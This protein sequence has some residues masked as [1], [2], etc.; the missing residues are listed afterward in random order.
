MMRWG[1]LLA[2]VWLSGVGGAVSPDPKDLAITPADLARARG[3]V[4]RLGSDDFQEREAAQAELALMGRLARPVL[5][6]ASTA[7]SNPEVRSR[8][9]RLLPRAEAQ[10]LKARIDTFRADESSRYEHDL[11]AWKQFRGVVGTDQ[12][13]RELYV[14]MLQ[15]PLDL[16]LLVAIDTSESEAGKAIADR[17]LSMYYKL[18]PGSFGRASPGVPLPAAEPPTAADV[19]VLMFA[20]ILV[21]SRAIPRAPFPF[22]PQITT[23]AFV[24]Q[25]A[26]HNALNGNAGAISAPYRRLFVR[27]LDSR[28]HP[29]DLSNYNMTNVANNFR[30]MPETTELLRR[31]VTVEGVAGIQK[32][33]G[34]MQLV[35]RNG[36]AEH[37]FLRSF[38]LA[39]GE[40]DEAGG[41][42]PAAA[43]GGSFQVV[44]PQSIRR[45]YVLSSMP[46]QQ[47]WFGNVNGL[48]QVRAW[49]Q[50]RDY[51]LGLLLVQAGQNL[52]DYGYDFPPGTGPSPNQV[53]YP[54]YAFI[55]DDQRSGD[56]KREAAIAKWRAFEAERALDMG[57][58]PNPFRRQP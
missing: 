30:T 38:V 5:A 51:A 34:L 39:D 44:G 52:R 27:W 58:K 33:Q 47:V 37:E 15:T 26:S 49:C 28:T 57:V 12:A 22:T 32:M 23:S 3:L 36:K 41:L 43:G 56:Q 4:Q 46:V 20:E 8:A 14:Q 18:Y 10:E 50:L 48:G 54:N 24:Q 53:G 9:A 2:V 55:D 16:E 35:Q 45:R 17:R 11:P 7:H 13:S 29:D 31:M 19:A 6:E 42:L 1:A 25:T 40:R 21:D